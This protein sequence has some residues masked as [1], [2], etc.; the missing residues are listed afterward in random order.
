MSDSLKL[1]LI[2]T[3]LA[4]GDPREV[5]PPATIEAVA[6]LEIFLA[7]ELRTA[8]RFVSALNLGRPIEE[9]QFYQLHKGTKEEQAEEMFDEFAGR[10]VGMLSEAGAPGVADPGSLAVAVAQSRGY[11]VVPHVGPSSLLLALM[12]SGFSGQSFVFHGYIPIDKKDRK[13]KLLAM[14]REV[15]R[16]GQTQLFMETPYRNEPL[17]DA[18]I[19]LL[20][21]DTL[22]C[23]AREL[24]DPTEQLIKTRCIAD[25]DSQKPELH[26]RPALFLLGRGSQLLTLPPIIRS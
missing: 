18:M 3:P 10:S 20:K 23:I 25:W 4:P 8:R 12:G 2:P 24:T 21:P 16:T 6:G 11:E 13:D 1:H 9:L 26:K 17:L 15:E 14:E 7:E 19:R 5:I 22:L